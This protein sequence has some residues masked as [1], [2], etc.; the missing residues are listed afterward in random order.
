MI[1]VQP[2]ITIGVTACLIWMQETSLTVSV[3]ALKFIKSREDLETCKYDNVQKCGNRSCT[4][5]DPRETGNLEI[6]KFQYLKI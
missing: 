2:V 4:N 3:V 1:A 5:L 6:W